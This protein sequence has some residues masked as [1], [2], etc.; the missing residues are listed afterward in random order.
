VAWS[1]GAHGDDAVVED[2]QSLDCG[3][4]FTVSGWD[5]RGVVFRRNTVIGSL[6]NGINLQD[7]PTA[8]LVEDNLAIRCTR[9][10]ANTDEWSG[11]IKMNS[12]ADTVFAHNV[13]LEAGNPET[14]N[15]HDGWAL[16]GD[17]NIVRIMYL[18]NTCADNKE[19]G[20]YIEWAM[21][22]TRAYFNT[23]Y[24]NG[25]GITCRQSQRGVFMHNLV[26]ESRGSGLAV[27]AG[28]APYPTTDQ[29]FAHN[30]VR[31]GNPCLW[32]QTEHPNFANYNTYWPRPDGDVAWGQAPD[33]GKTPRY[34][35]LAEW[36]KASGHDLRSEVRDAQPADV[37]LDV[38]TFRVADA[39]D[40][41]QVLMMV[42]NGGCEWE[43]PAGQNI[44]PYFWRPGSGDGVPHTFVYAAYCGLDGGCEH[45]AYPGAGGT[46]QLR[47]DSP[48]PNAPKLAHGG[49]RCLL[50]QGWKPEQMNPEGLGFWSPSLPARPGDVCTVRFFARGEDLKPAA[51]VEALAAL[52]EFSSA[53]GQQRS[54]VA[55][56]PA[57]PV[58]PT[59]AWQAV[60]A[61]VS[62]P[63]AA[64][65]LRLFLG[66]R[67]A[68][69]RLLLDDIQLRV[70]P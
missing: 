25:H 19:A 24:R 68:T 31:G 30:L 2:C 56:A 38:V 20:L 33:G 32:L 17:I 60:E 6:H 4:G 70:S 13:V 41:A 63:P 27:W 15:G 9:N 18:G 39:T 43:D 7:R 54:R 35:D 64:R 53:T 34:K 14:I 49:L 1:F 37:G 51:G 50:I 3:M 21:G 45:L 28:P 55:L 44:L 40:P 52:V 16:W 58:A 5:R 59:S 42:G 69:G 46:V 36:T 61:E 57:I 48:D 10:P 29:V 47:N 8:C 22:D 11:S 67:P 65:R 23:S 66:L 62:V 12:A 26:L